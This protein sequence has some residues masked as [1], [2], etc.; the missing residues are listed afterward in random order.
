MAEAAGLRITPHISAGEIGFVYMLQM[1][2]VSPTMDNYHGFKI[3]ETPYAKG[4][5]IPM[6]SKAEKFESIDGFIKSTF[7]HRNGLLLIPVI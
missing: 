4:T 3:F 2:S 1:V 6:E 5:I 7:R